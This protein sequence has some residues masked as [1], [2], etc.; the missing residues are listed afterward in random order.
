MS[1]AS[2]LSGGVAASTVL[3]V[4]KDRTCS[5]P[6]RG[7]VCEGVTGEPPLRLPTRST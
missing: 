6:V 1:R 3:S 2:S 7:Q 4:G 5:V